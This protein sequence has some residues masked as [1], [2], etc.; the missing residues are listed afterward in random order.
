MDNKDFDLFNKGYN[1]GFMYAVQL[2]TSKILHLINN[3]PLWMLKSDKAIAEAKIKIMAK[4]ILQKRGCVPY[5]YDV[6]MGKEKA[7]ELDFNI[8]D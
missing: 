3:H 2:T 4:R 5:D 1:E 6:I 7:V 8:E